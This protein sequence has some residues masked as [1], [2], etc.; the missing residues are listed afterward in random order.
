MKDVERFTRRLHRKGVSVTFISNY[1]W[2]YLN[3]VNGAK[4][5]GTYM[6]DHGFT[7]FFN[8][9]N[10]GETITDISTVFKKIKETLNY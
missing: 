1:P 6:G 5:R 8:N 4:I 10:G 7:A 2:I 3:T 9:K